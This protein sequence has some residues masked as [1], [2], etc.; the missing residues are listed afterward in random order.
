MTYLEA[1]QRER[2]RWQARRDEVVRR[3]D[4]L[5]KEEVALLDHLRSIESHYA[6]ARVAEATA[7]EL[8][9]GGTSDGSD[10]GGD[11]GKV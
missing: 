8:D 10:R 11:A 6:A 7:R 4:L 9:R 5:K 1:I 2:A 3:L